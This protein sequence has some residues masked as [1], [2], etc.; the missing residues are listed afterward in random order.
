MSCSHHF[1]TSI[2]FQSESPS[3]KRRKTSGSIVDLTNTSPSPP[4]VALQC[5][6]G[7]ADRLRRRNPS[8]R[9]PSGERSHTPRA[10]RR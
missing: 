10:R 9:R 2:S 3:R 7:P 1:H 6:Q 4:T 5:E 8:Q